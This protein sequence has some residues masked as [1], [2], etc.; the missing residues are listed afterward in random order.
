[1]SDRTVFDFLLIF[2]LVGIL[3]GLLAIDGLSKFN[4]RLREENRRR[5]LREERGVRRNVRSPV[6]HVPATLTHD[7]FLISP[8]A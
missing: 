8:A 1:M 6:R 7:E 2:Y 5:R 4:R 3:L